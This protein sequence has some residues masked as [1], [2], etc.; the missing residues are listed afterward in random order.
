MK[1]FAH[2]V[3]KGSKRVGTKGHWTGNSVAF[4]TPDGTFVVVMS[5]P[6]K[7]SRVVRLSNGAVTRAFELEPESFNTIVFK[8]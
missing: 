4:E 5:N 8:K 6:F 1:H 7:D 3:P 2:F